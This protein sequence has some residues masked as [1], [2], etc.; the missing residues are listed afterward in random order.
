MQQQNSELLRATAV[1]A[2]FAIGAMH[3]LQ[4]VDTLDA[5][6]LLGVAYVLLIASSIV[7]AMRLLLS[8][9]PRAWLGAALL[10]A[11]IMVGYAFTRL[12]G[13]TF[14]AEDVGNW[15]CALGLASLFVEGVLV[16]I[17]ACAITRLQSTPAAEAA[18]FDR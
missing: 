10:G 14:D 16:G 11:A 4:I 15:A 2:L 9:D 13:T 1:I 7:L 3:F 18:V 12:I 6:P 17:S 8:N 5:T